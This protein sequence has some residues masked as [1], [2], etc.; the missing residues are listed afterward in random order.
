MSASY[1][2]RSFPIWN[3]PN[4]P[5]VSRRIFAPSYARI[6]ESFDT[7]NFP[8]G[9]LIVTLLLRYGRAERSSMNFARDV[10]AGQGKWG[11]FY[12]GSRTCRAVF[13]ICLNSSIP[14]YGDSHTKVTSSGSS[15]RGDGGGAVKFCSLCCGNT[16]E[17]LRAAGCLLRDNTSC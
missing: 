1:L 6:L 15:F 10:A 4:Q 3:V 13:S 11:S 7:R 2:S 9:N 14:E 5:H 12:F 17:F 16:V 8:L